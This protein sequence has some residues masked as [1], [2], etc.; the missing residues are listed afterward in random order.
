MSLIYVLAMAN[1]DDD[2]QD[3]VIKDLIYDAINAQAKAINVRCTFYLLAVCRPGIVFKPFE[4]A[5]KLP[6]YLF[7][8]GPDEISSIL[9]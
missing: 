4:L 1:S 3:P 9:C 2:D 8:L 7:G 5:G 6:L